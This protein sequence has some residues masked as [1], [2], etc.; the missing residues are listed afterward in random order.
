MSFLRPSRG[1]SQRSSGGPSAPQTFVAPENGIALNALTDVVLTTPATNDVLKYDGTN[2]INSVGGGGATNLAYTA[3]A[4]N[5]IVTSDT[6]TDATIPLT[7]ATNA[8]LFT[9]AQKTKLD[10]IATAATANSS[11]ATLLD[12]ANHTGSQAISTITSLQ[13]S[14]DNKLDD[15]QATAF[16]LSL[17]DDVDAAAGRTTLGLG[18]LATQSGTFSG[19]SSGTNTG[20]QTSIVGITGSLAEFNTALTGADFATGGGT[21]TGT[22]SGTNTGDQTSIVGITGTIA[23]FNTALSDGDFATGGGTATGTNTGD[24]T[25]TLTG[26]VTGSGTG[27]F[28]ATIANSAVTLAKMADVATGTVFYRKT[29]ATGVPEVQTLATL[30]TDLGLTGTNSGDQTI[31]LTSDV[32]GSGTGSFA[33]TIAADAVTNTKL[34]NMATATF[35]GRTTAGT[36]DPEDLSATQA[37]ALLNVMVGDAGAGGTKGLVPT[38]VTGDATKFLRGDG[39]FVAIPGGGDALVAN[40]L[41]QF[42]ATTSA[43]LKGVISDETGSGGALV[44]ATGPTLSSPILAAGDASNPAI[45]LTSQTLMTTPTDGAIEMDANC[46]YG[47]T[48]AGNRGVIPLINYVC[49]PVAN[50]TLTSTTAEQ[51]IFPAANDTLTLETGLYFY[52]VLMYISSMSATAGNAAFDLLGAGTATITRLS[53]HAGQDA[54]IGIPGNAIGSGDIAQTAASMITGATGTS[55][56]FS[57]QGAFRVTAA[58]TIIPSITLVTA[59]AAVVNNQSYFMCYRMG[60]STAEAVG[61]WS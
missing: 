51:A 37:T 56:H 42:A 1:G 59:A 31:T 11:D 8:G 17:L 39:T 25:I 5:G 9:A 29:A 40:P 60:S 53:R 49:I 18:T 41:S 28:A 54:A 45:L 55:M 33:T 4:T 10:G 34:A 14:L 2:W 35:K 32:T 27:S 13:T 36:G 48:D 3:S 30:K 47:T 15:S 7:D 24:Q 20:D 6:G 22:S 16:G 21:V 57:M 52:D 38:P 50:Y 43:Q 12:R 26:N 23:Q 19:T 46:M 44:F 61:Q 58:G